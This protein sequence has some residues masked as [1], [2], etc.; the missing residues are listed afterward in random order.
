MSIVPN[1]NDVLLGRGY[2]INN[3]PGNLSL[4]AL[5]DSKRADFMAIKR[6]DKRPM[7]QD[8]V[9][10]VAG[11]GGRFLREAR[12][13]YG[14]G[15]ES[16]GEVVALDKRRWNE[17]DHSTAVEK[18]MH[19]FR[20]K[21]KQ[22]SKE[23]GGPASKSA[24]LGEGMAAAG[25]LVL[26]D[27]GSLGNVLSAPLGDQRRGAHN[28]AS[29]QNAALLRSLALHDGHAGERG[30]LS[31]GIPPS[32][33]FSLTAGRTSGAGGG[34]GNN[35]LAALALQ[36]NQRQGPVGVQQDLQTALL[37]QQQQQQQQMHH[38]SVF[39]TTLPNRGLDAVANSSGAMAVGF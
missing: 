9:G 8:V 25:N 27:W 34:V 37:L 28:Q 16:N 31:S 38:N 35:M 32:A 13:D 39:A 10:R 5:V 36:Q 18:V 3:H 15:G 11:R 1:D 2:A 4:R 20:E 26:G 22:G 12:N 23:D 30:A 21:A 17:V 24:G 29:V 14:D 19:L 7:A 33:V 6:T